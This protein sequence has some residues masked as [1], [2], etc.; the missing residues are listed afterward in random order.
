VTAFLLLLSLRSAG[1]LLRPGSAGRVAISPA[2]RL[3]EDLARLISANRAELLALLIE[4]D[5]KKQ[6]AE[7][8][9]AIAAWYADHPELPDVALVELAFVRLEGL[10]DGPLV[11][12]EAKI[13]ES[14]TAHNA[15]AHAARKHYHGKELMSCPLC[16]LGGEA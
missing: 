11:A 12:V 13:W 1:F 2:Q 9:R 5:Q 4:E 15:R 3:T 7:R 14:L 16:N 8:D 6:Q 10:E